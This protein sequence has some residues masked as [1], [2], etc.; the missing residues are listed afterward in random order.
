[1]S[2]KVEDVDSTSFDKNTR[3]V[4]DV[5]NDNKYTCLYLFVLLM[6]RVQ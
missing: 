2:N 3:S 5:S 1:M 4:E 6:H